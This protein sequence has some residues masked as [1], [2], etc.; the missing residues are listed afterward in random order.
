[1]LTAELTHSELANTRHVVTVPHMLLHRPQADVAGPVVEV[2]NLPLGN[3]HDALCQRDGVRVQ[4][5]RE[6]LQLGVL[7]DQA[8]PVLISAAHHNLACQLARFC[9]TSQSL[10]LLRPFAPLT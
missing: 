1:M 2:D 10:P 4:G 7:R 3:P 5:G 6:A 8:E 9:I